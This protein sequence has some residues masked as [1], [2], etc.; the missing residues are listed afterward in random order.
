MNRV[1]QL[2]LFTEGHATKAD[3]P[4]EYIKDGIT[5]E[6]HTPV[7]KMHKYFARRPHN[8]FRRL[9]EQ[10]TSPGDVILDTF[11]GGGVT[12]VEA[13]FAARKAVGIDI[14]PLATF[15]TGCELSPV[16]LDRATKLLQELRDF[17]E[18]LTSR[19]FV[20][21]CRQ[22]GKVV[23]AR[24]YDLTYRVKCPA[25]SQETLLGNDDK[26][27]VN[28]V[29]KNGVYTCRPCKKEFKAVSARRIGDKLLSV[30]YKE[31]SSGNRVSHPAN[32]FDFQVVRSAEEEL[33]NQLANGGLWI[34]NDEIP[35]DWDRQQEDCLH[36][37]SINRFAD[38]FTQRTLLVVASVF[39]YIESRRNDLSTD[40]Y[41]LLVFLFSAFI[42]FTNRLTM[43]TSNWMDG[44]PVAWAKH[45]YWIPNQFV[46][47]NPIEYIE[48]RGTAI[49]AG[50]TFQ[51][52][53][54]DT[55]KR[56]VTFDK[57]VT[58]DCTHL[59]VT[60]SSESLSI[61][62]STVDLVLTDPPYGSNVQY[63]E[64]SAYW[65][66]WIAKALD[67]G[68]SDS[69]RA[70]AIVHRKQAGKSR[71]TFM[72]YY[73]KLRAIFSE[74]YRVLKPGRPLVFTFN[75]KDVRSWFAVIKA[76]VDSGFIL[77]QEGVVYQEP[78]ENYK[79]TAHT[80]HHGT[81]HGDF[82]Y[83]F[84][85]PTNLAAYSA[86][87]RRTTGEFLLEKI[88]IEAASNAVD[89]KGFAST[90]EVY[91]KVFADLIPHLVSVAE[92]T[93]DVKPF[94]SELTF[95]SL[96]RILAKK[97]IFDKATKAWKRNESNDIVPD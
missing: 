10:Y 16:N 48:K 55:P 42:R 39:G 14:N 68:R 44:R 22:S 92:A 1:K 76:V 57:L 86:W 94:L 25:C 36:R 20:T 50:L 66:V 15:V 82:I 85:K 2:H 96:D 45:A 35:A 78:I 72:F 97:F 58:T 51:Q 84:I 70:E 19:L 63:G 54:T 9:I 30:T 5:A 27:I 83:T 32:E 62:D 73:E 18:P 53:N 17:V 49:K 60:A 81:V 79:N 12:I 59:L 40:D 47:V 31:P 88:V 28:G 69:L 7:Y 4:I 46:E 38:L 90:S 33:A 89:E 77:E 37:K 64:L 6:S 8:V 71:K 67:W 52:R 93:K 13:V 56:A 61:P 91:V 26:L 24:W 75:N 21:K 43:S 3:S 80:R 87:K 41:E 34:P 11:C 74:A 65:T 95:S 29:S 23:N